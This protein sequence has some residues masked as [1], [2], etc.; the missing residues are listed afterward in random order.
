MKISSKFLSCIKFKKLF[1]FLVAKP[2]LQLYVFLQ[3]HNKTKLHLCFKEI[4][5]SVKESCKIIL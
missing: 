1:K 3:T 5:I 2:G 4:K